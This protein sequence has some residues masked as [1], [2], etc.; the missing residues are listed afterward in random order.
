MNL[1]IYFLLGLLLLGLG[2]CTISRMVVYQFSDIKD[3]KKFPSRPLTPSE[4]P[5]VFRKG[6]E[7]AFADRDIRVNTG[8]RRAFLDTL[9]MDSKTVGFL[10]IQRDSILYERYFDKYEESSLV[11][12]FSMAKSFT[13]ALFGI[14]IEEGHIGSVDDFLV[15]Y[16]PELKKQGLDDIRLRDVLQMTTGIHHAENYFNPFAGVARLYYGRRLRKQ[17]LKLRQEYEAGLYFH[18]MSVNTQLLGEVLVRATGKTLTEYMQE[19]IWG[20]IGM[21]YPASWSIDQRRNGIEKAFCCINAAARDFAKFG[22]LYLRGG[23]WEGKQLVPTEW[24][25]M[26][27]KVDAQNG[28]RVGYQYQWWLP[29]KEGDFTAEG[30]LGQFIYVNPMKDLVIV[31]LGKNYG[32]VYWKKAFREIAAQL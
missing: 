6:N 17:V 19:K 12:S 32:G 26:S 8:K 22:R 1:R 28:A 30:H 31:R 3:Y 23:N 21:E 29:S 24:V 5:F 27:T 25:K 4:T 13:S 10:V 14:A 11:A 20:P 15:D 7:Q 18:Y 9:L 2:S 16:I